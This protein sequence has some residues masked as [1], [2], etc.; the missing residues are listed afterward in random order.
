MKIKALK[1]LIY[2]LSA[3]VFCFLVFIPTSKAS[4]KNDTLVNSGFK[5]KTIIVD[6]GHGERPS[7][8]GRYSPGAEGTYSFERTVTL[9]IAQKL[10][11]AIEKNMP[12]V[13]VVMT[14]T[15][16]EDVPFQ[17]RADIANQNKGD[18]FIS[19]HCNALPNR[20]VRQ[21]VGRKK[22]KP[23]YKNVSVPDRSGKG[24]LM[25]LYST[26]RTGPQLDALR[27]NAEIGGSPNDARTAEAQDPQTVI[28]INLLKNK[29]RKQS[30]HLADLLNKEFI[31][32]GRRSEGLREQVLYV[33]DHT[34]MPSVMVETGYINNKEEE[35][36]LNSEEGQ[37][38][39]ANAILR[40]IENYK[41]DAEKR[42]E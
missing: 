35:D 37:E 6:A 1:T 8:G 40:G 2:A 23:V 13:K 33:L 19:I 3:F 26:E 27:E 36:F 10:Q 38:E 28:L 22:G 4:V 15:T 17:K 12:D 24:V 18:L 21:V 16:P 31:L 11:K 7:G 9:A 25:L 32:D 39:V 30:I 20:T 41:R 5:I 29:Y 42:S 14:R 34:A